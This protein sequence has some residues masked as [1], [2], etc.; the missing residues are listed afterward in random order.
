MPKI[1]ILDP[2]V[3]NLISAGEVVERPASIVKE[4]VENSI[5][6]GATE[7][8]ISLIDGGLTSI[9][10][11]DNGIGIDSQDLDVCYL[12]HTTSKIKTSS[13]LDDISTLGFRGEAL[14]S[15]TAVAQVN[16]ATKIVDSE[17]GNFIQINGG[18]VVDKGQIGAKQGTKIQVE[19]IFFN[20]PV[21]RKFLKKP[22]QEESIASQVVT[23]LIFANPDVKFTYSCDDKIIY[24]TN[25]GLENAI[26]AI[27]STDIA[28]KMI[29]FDDTYDGI[30]VY[31]Y[32]GDKTLSKHNRSYQTIIVNGRTISNTTIQTAVMQAYGNILMKRCYPVY[33]LNIVMPFED[34]DVNV[35]PNKKEVRFA[36]N[37]RIFSRVYHTISK[38]LATQSSSLIFD[39]YNIG[40]YT[41]N[42]EQ[43]ATDQIFDNKNMLKIEN[44]QISNF[45]DTSTNISKSQQNDN[46][47]ISVGDFE[48]NDNL[49]ISDQKLRQAI[50]AQEELVGNITKSSNTYIDRKSFDKLSDNLSI[51]TSVSANNCDYTQSSLFEQIEQTLSCE[52]K[53]VG[54][55]FDTYLILEVGSKA[56]VI[57]QHA[58]HERILYDQLIEKV[59]NSQVVRQPMLI[60]YIIECNNAQYEYVSS[61]LDILSSFGFDIQEFG[62]L[63]FKVDSI[64]SLLSDINLDKFF[65]DILN[66]KNFSASLKKSDLVKDNLAQLACKSAIKAGDK[67]NEN[68]IRSLVDN[69]NKGIPMQCPHGRPT[70]IE[71][72]RTQLDKLFKRIV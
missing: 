45:Q 18:K 10:V 40:Q 6:A 44:E 41:D 39:G 70:V 56:F 52:Y 60:P 8:D 65:D 17:I 59:N 69:M 67:L 3:Y 12:P 35:H 7:I 15:I 57:D 2:S 4:L 46:T 1:N 48:N 23:E 42:K 68:Q 26:Y 5:D 71:V 49:G 33:I 63:S 34:V 54:Q 38:A 43:T 66:E 72:T 55:L 64:P 25:G 28:N 32:T 11:A 58:C 36:D 27:Y 24:Q 9:V 29:A 62:G 50:S 51:H 61:I 13:D 19:N 21:R 37:Q 30:R 20:T 14:A 53:I 47:S 22:K 31:G 16:I